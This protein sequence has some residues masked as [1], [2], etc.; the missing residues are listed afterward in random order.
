MAANQIGNVRREAPSLTLRSCDWGKLL[1]AFKKP[2]LEAGG[3]IDTLPPRELSDV[4][5]RSEADEAV[6]GSSIV[7]SHL[8][9][10]S[11]TGSVD[12]HAGPVWLG[13]GSASVHRDR[14]YIRRLLRSAWC[15]GI[16]GRESRQ[17]GLPDRNTA[18][19]VFG[20][21]WRTNSSH[22]IG[23][24]SRLLHTRYNGQVNRSTDQ[25]YDW[26]RL[27]DAQN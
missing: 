10:M 22:G 26:R 8:H 19:R 5:T 23:S 17:F 3:G 25:Q 13:D 2:V 27:V 21:H 20:F 15:I 16:A 12:E 11:R 18:R 9:R 6:V 14:G 24:D 7:N 4:W 1:A